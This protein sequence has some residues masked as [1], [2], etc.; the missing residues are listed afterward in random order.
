LKDLS[1]KRIYVSFRLYDTQH[2]VTYQVG[3]D[4]L[5]DL[6]PLQRLFAAQMQLVGICGRDEDHA[7]FA[8]LQHIGNDQLDG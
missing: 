4:G 5:L 2:P 1:T 6:E 3:H 7:M 8:C